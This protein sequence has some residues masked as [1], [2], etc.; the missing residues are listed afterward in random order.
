MRASKTPSTCYSAHPS[1]SIDTIS[2]KGFIYV[3]KRD[4]STENFE[5][6]GERKALRSVDK[7]LNAHLVLVYVC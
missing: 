1:P 4:G 6:D 7:I 5:D 2:E 3:N